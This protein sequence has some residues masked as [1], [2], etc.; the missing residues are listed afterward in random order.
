M[1]FLTRTLYKWSADDDADSAVVAV[2]VAAADVD[3][4][5]D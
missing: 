2:V 5:E 1:F 3:D 4:G